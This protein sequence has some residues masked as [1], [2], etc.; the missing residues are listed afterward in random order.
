ME[1]EVEGVFVFVCGE[2]GLEFLVGF[3]FGFCVRQAL[4]MGGGGCCNI[5]YD[6]AALPN[7]LTKDHLPDGLRF[8]PPF[9]YLRTT[10]RPSPPP[11][12]SYAY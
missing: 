1:V 11:N 2:V 3:V 4:P 12:A 5:N 8:F 9:F 6:D 10:A 7:K